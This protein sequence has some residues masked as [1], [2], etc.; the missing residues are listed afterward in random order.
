MRI[1]FW[2]VEALLLSIGGHVVLVALLFY[3]ILELSVLP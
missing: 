2:L 1:T 3:C